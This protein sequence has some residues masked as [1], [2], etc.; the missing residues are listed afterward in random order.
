[1]PSPPGGDPRPPEQTPHPAQQG[2]DV[3]VCSRC[4]KVS[5]G[6]P[7]T[8]T[9]SVENGRRQ[10]FCDDCARANL[11]AIEGRLDSPWW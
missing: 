5:E 3:V 4:G 6:T 9:C 8:W 2:A 10:Y 7:L 1:M 11:R